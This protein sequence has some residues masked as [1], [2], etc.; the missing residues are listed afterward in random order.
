ME[1]KMLALG[2]ANALRNVCLEDPEYS[3]LV[4]HVC[5]RLKYI[6]L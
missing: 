3:E 4:V 1:I 6:I 2:V 5:G